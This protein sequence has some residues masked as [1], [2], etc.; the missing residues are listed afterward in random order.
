MD[1]ASA[2]QQAL[3]AKVA[4]LYD[5][6]KSYFEV[7]NV[8]ASGG[9][10]GAFDALRKNQHLAESFVGDLKSLMHI[11]RLAEL[12]QVLCDDRSDLRIQRRKPAIGR[13]K[14]SINFF[15]SS[16]YLPL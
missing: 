12:I 14:P 7:T 10:W 16:F 11:R 13:L 1:H 9:Y 5:A 8:G 3:R 15:M 4:E 6:V 2:E